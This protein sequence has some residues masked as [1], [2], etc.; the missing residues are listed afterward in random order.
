[1]IARR[2]STESLSRMVGAKGWQ[3]LG[4]TGEKSRRE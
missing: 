2:A 1:M 4:L 3:Y